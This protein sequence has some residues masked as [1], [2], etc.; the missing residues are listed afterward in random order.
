[1]GIQTNHAEVVKVI[2]DE[3]VVS[4]N[5]ILD[6]FFKIHDPTQL[7]RQGWDIGSQYRSII[8]ATDKAQLE[9]AE[10][11]KKALEE[12]S[13]F[14]KSIATQIEILPNYYKAEEYHQ[15]YILKKMGQVP[16]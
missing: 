10:M 14:N 5:E 2:F 7:N 16:L 8:F 11:T 6:F 3:E 13:T 1:M 15:K 12:N 9:V 4:Y